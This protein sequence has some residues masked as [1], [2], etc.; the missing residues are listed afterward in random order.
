MRWQ[1]DDGGRAMA[2]YRGLAG[3]CATRAAAIVTGRSYQ[4]VY[5][6]I[7]A[8]GARERASKRRKSKSHP[9]TGVY[10]PTYNRLMMSYGFTWVPAMGIGTG[11]QVHLKDGE[12]PDDRPI[13]CRVSKHYTAVID[14]VIHDTYDPS[15]D[16]TRCVYGWWEP[17]T[18]GA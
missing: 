7:V 3:D 5:D 6:D 12:L 1:Y 15:R 11:C 8:L 14:G 4:Q 16:G 17:K 9:R 2:G 13:V 10:A 18:E